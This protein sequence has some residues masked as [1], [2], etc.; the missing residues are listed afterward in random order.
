MEERIQNLIQSLEDIKSNEALDTEEYKLKPELKSKITVELKAIQTDLLKS[1][2]D[3][4]LSFNLNLES[5]TIP[6]LTE[7]QP[8]PPPPPPAAEAAEEEGEQKQEAPAAAVATTA[9]EEEPP[10]AAVAPTEEGKDNMGDDFDVDDNE[11]DPFVGG[12]RKQKTKKNK[13]RSQK[14]TQ[15]NRK[16]N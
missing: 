8:P 9:A 16:N 15:K 10:T 1:I 12:N 7:E 14:N 3:F 11:E 5:S 4:A 2:S 13:R 6:P